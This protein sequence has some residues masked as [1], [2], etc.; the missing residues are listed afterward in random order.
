MQR[1]GIVGA[2]AW[3][4]A[5]ALT[6]GARDGT[7]S[8]GRATPALAEEID[9]R[10]ENRPYL[11]DVALDAAIRVSPEPAELTPCDA[12]LLAI[13]AQHLRAVSAELTEHITEKQPLI[14]CSKGIEQTSLKLMTEVLAEILPGRP[15]A[16]L[17]GPNF[18]AEVARGLPAAATPGRRGQ[19]AGRAAGR[20]AGQQDLPAP[21][22]R[23]IPWARRWAARSRT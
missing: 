5:L 3:G 21:T 14:V 7:W 13:P 20:G 2:G 1:I 16:V 11:P 18:A 6:S 15:L 9:A 12:L 23:P 22:Y 4:T 8:F 10:R 19:G 17:S